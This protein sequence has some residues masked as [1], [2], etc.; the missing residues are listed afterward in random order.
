M[1]D[2]G[3]LLPAIAERFLGE[4][5]SRRGVTLAYGTHGSLKLDLGKGT[6]FDH[7]NDVGGGVVDLLLREVPEL[8]KAEPGSIADYLHNEFGLEKRG[9]R[10]QVRFRGAE[11]ASYAALSRGDVPIPR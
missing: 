1:D 8:A 2:I 3:N 9:E 7:E 10:R 11:N 6:W 5:S 4:P